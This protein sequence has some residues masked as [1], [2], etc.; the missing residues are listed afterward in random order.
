[1]S[2]RL[3]QKEI[4]ARRFPAP[5]K[6]GRVSVWPVEVLRDSNPQRVDGGRRWRS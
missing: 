5:V 3:I 4:S 6:V 1:V 2:K